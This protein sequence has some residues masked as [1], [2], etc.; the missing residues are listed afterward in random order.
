MTVLRDSWFYD[1]I[2]E[3]MDGWMIL[4][5]KGYVGAHKETECI[6]AV[7]KTNMKE[8]KEYSKKYWHQFNVARADVERVFAHFFH[9]KF[10]QLSKW[11]GKSQKTFIKFS[12]NVI[13]CVILYNLVKQHFPVI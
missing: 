1:N 6:A 11:P 4:A 13:C 2:D 12:A 10:T 7:L 5:D 3:I 9:N 8:R